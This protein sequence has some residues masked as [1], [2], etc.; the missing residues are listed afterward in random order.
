MNKQ[1]FVITIGP[2]G[3]GK[4][5]QGFLLAERFGLYL[6]E[7]SKILEKYFNNASPDDYLEVDGTKYYVKDEIEMRGQGIL[8]SPPFVTKMVLDKIEELYNNGK[9]IITSG[10]PRTLYE[11]EK[12]VPLLDKLYGKDNIVVC[13]LEQDVD[14]SIQRN[15][16]RRVCTLMRHS[17][18]H[19]DE[20]KDLT[21][22][23]IDG[24][25]LVKRQ[26]VGDDV[27]HIK[28]RYKEYK[29]RTEPLVDFFREQGL[30]VKIIDASK[31]PAEVFNELV[32]FLDGFN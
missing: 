32:S 14:V 13:V 24:S 31:T 1:R 29:E 17:I 4:G 26:G 15:S 20:F 25:E 16:N 11:G 18:L 10:S 6:F 2:P 23:P 19:S 3:S 5:T 12:F 7:T 27:E 22:C 9:S 8:N 28:V 21:H 30:K